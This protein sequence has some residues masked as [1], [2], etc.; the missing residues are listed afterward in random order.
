MEKELFL[1]IKDNYSDF[2]SFAVWR[3]WEDVADLSIFEDPGIIEGLNTDFV[4]VALNPAVH[5]ETRERRPFDNFHSS[6]GKKQR[7]YKLCFALESTH[8]YGSYITDLFKGYSETDSSVVIK[9]YAS[10]E[11]NV[12]EDITTLKEELM[13]LNPDKKP[14]LIAI[15]GQVEKYLK[16]YL[17]TEYL[18]WKISHYSDYHRDTASQESY[19]DT[20]HK[21]LFELDHIYQFLEKV[22][23][24]HPTEKVFFVPQG[25]KRIKAQQYTYGE[26]SLVILPSTVTSIGENAFTKKKGHPVD[27]VFA[28]TQLEWK[29]RDLGKNLQDIPCVQCIDG[30]T[31]YHI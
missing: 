19:R 23:A 6:D 11:E 16:K 4:F 24:E 3:C 30:L 14:V 28:G 9:E 8:F 29:E 25:T 17:G 15:G 5:N 2:S 13:L 20:V 27:V 18:V 7:D 31:V 22:F 12:K 21:Q 26:G 1:R 10:N